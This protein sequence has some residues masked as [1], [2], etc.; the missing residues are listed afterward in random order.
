MSLNRV[1]LIGNVGK[2]P[3]IRYIDNGVCTA[4]FPLATTTRGYKLPNGTEVPER[5]EWH[6]ILIW[7][8]LAEVVEKYVHKGDKLYIGGE[9]RTRTWTDKRGQTHKVTEVWAKEMEMLT[10]RGAREA[11]PP[12]APTSAPAPAE[13]NTASADTDDPPF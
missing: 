5:T 7:R 9:L 3:L 6:D 12:A 1:M 2:E 8:H 10:P 11:A 13:G 4:A